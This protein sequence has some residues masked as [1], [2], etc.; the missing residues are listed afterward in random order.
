MAAKYLCDKCGKDLA[1][2]KP[3]NVC[4]VIRTEGYQWYTY[5]LC[6]NCTDK[7]LEYLGSKDS[8]KAT[9]T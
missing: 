8:G 3:F 6:N 9:D 5:Q 7:L 4:N 1:F 2:I